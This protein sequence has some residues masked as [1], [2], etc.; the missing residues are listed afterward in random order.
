MR[1][2]RPTASVA[3]DVGRLVTLAARQTSTPS[4]GMASPC[5]G[6]WLPGLTREA[7]RRCT[8]SRP[9]S[10]KGRPGL[11]MKKAHRLQLSA[12]EPGLA[13]PHDR[14]RAVGELELGEDVRNVV[15]DGLGA[16]HEHLGDF[17]IAAS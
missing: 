2:S 14:F 6:A 7:A 10:L 16:E 5:S 15:A 9:S 17:A 4:N 12:A 3:D 11:A 1:R 13:G 8:P